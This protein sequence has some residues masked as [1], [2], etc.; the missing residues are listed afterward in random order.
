MQS[1]ENKVINR[2]YGK[3]RGWC[4]TP[5]SFSDLG[6]QSAIR[7]ALVRLEKDN[8]IRRLGRGIY[9]YPKKHKKIG[10]LPP[11]IKQ[12]A[13]A[14]A[15]KHSLKIQ[16]SGALA[17]NLLGLSEQVPA[18]V[19]FLTDGKGKKVM[20]GKTEVTFKSVAPR[21]MSLA[22]TTAGLLVQALKYFGQEHV[23]DA[24]FKRAWSKLESKDKQRLVKKKNTV[25]I[26][27]HKFIDKF[28]AEDDI[29]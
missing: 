26:W 27:L 9:D 10:L 16:P 18:K 15:K 23:D 24:M 29:G 4:F 22:G 13:E 28:A 1:I 20:I 21:F 3:G 25:P 11:D 7:Q 8:I 19:V 17:A 5:S 12:A 2:I 6:S 14:I